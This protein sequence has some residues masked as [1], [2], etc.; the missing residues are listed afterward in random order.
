MKESEWKRKEKSKKRKGIKKQFWL[1]EK[2]AAV[3]KDYAE[4]TGLTEVSLIRLLLRGYAPKERPDDRFYDVMNQ[5]SS[6]SNNIN[7]LAR[8]ANSLNFIDA[9]MLYREAEE[10]IKF[11]LEVQRHFICPDRTHWFDK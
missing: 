11:R 7:Q 8:K 2:D 10:W 1:S 3:L 6:I 9:P 4:R 5:L